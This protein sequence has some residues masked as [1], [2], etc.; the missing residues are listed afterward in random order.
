MA[1]AVEGL[2]GSPPPGSRSADGAVAAARRPGQQRRRRPLRR[3][4]P[5]RGRLNAVAVHH[6]TV[7]EGARAAAEAAGVVLTTDPSALGEADV[8]LDG[9]LGIGGR[10]GLP[11]WAREWVARGARD[12][13]VIAV[14]L[15]SGQDPMGGA[16]D[17]DGRLRRR[18]GD[19]LGRQAGAPAAAHR[20][21][22]RRADG[23]RHRPRGADGEP[24]VR[25]L[26][27]DDVAALWPVPSRPT[28]STPAACSASSPAA[29]PTPG[30]PCSAVTAAVE[31][32][33][34]MVRYVGTPRRPASSAGA[35]PE[36]VH[37]PGRSRPG[38][39]GPASTPTPRASGPAQLDVARE[40]LRR[41][42]AGRR[43]RRWARPARRAVLTARRDRH[44][45]HAARGRV[46]PA[47]HPPR[48]DRRGRAAAGRV[49][50]RAPAGRTPARS[51]PPN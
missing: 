9:I 45:A 32:G 8:V 10:P 2:A 16:L 35:V 29:S 17:P 13:H 39:S 38:S 41:R 23:R 30:Q 47:P 36:A 31:A 40:A 28:T 25:R 46:R 48:H 37:G 11:T 1:R 44:P 26:D 43:R 12:A 4:P 21:G 34:G 19:L 42:R 15:P 6:G 14:D 24:V 3:R 49:A 7:H 27:H 33:R 51:P 22:V 18:D 5:R 20:A 50:L